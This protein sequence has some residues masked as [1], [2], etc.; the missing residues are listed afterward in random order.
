MAGDWVVV[1]PNVM[2]SE[3][4][5]NNNTGGSPA[6]GGITLGFLWTNETALC[7]TLVLGTFFLAAN[8]ILFAAI[9]RRRVACAKRDGHRQ[10]DNPSLQATRAEAVPLSYFQNEAELSIT[11]LAIAFQM[12]ADG[13][14][15]LDQK[16]Q[17]LWKLWGK[18]FLLQDSQYFIASHK[19]DL[20]NTMGVSEKAKMDTTLL[21]SKAPQTPKDNSLVKIAVEMAGKPP[22]LIEFNQKQPLATIIQDL[23]NYWNLT[24][25]ET[26]ALRF[27]TET[28]RAFVSE[29]NRLEVKNGHVLQLGFSPGK[30]T[31][32]ILDQLSPQS[33][34][35]DKMKAIQELAGYAT[36]PTFTAEFTDKLGMKTLIGYVENTESGKLS[37]QI[38]VHLLPAF[39]DLMD[40]GLTQWDVLE[41]TFI[42]R[43]ASF[44]NN[45]SSAQ[46]P[47]TLQAALSILESLAQNSSTKYGIVER[48]LTIPNLAMHL[49]NTS[50][51]IQQNTLALINAL[52]LK[53]DDSKRTAMSK[54]LNARQIRNIIVMSII[55]VPGVASGNEIAHQLHVLQTL[56]L[57]VLEEAMNCPIEPGDMEAQEKIKELRRIAFDNDGS[58]SLTPV[59]DVATRKQIIP[60]DFRKL[61]FKNDA[62]PL[63]DFAQVPPGAL[64]LDAMLYFASYH[65]EKYSRVVLENSGRGDEYDCP[66]VRAAIELIKLLCEILK[67]GEPP[68]EQG[69]LFHP[70]FFNHDHPFEELFC[71]CIVVVNK[72]WKEMRATV[73]DF[74][75]VF[76]V[77]REQIT[78]VLAGRPLTQEIFKERIAALT[79]AEITDLWQ[80]ERT[81]REKWESRS[82]P[83]MELRQ[84]I[85]PEI[86]ELIQQQR[87]GF[88]TEGT[89]FSKYTNRGRVKD[90]F[91]YVRLSPNH[92]VLH[93][94]DCDEK[95][96]PALDEL[97][98]KLPIVD[99]R[100]LVTGKDC[101]HMK[102]LKGKKTTSQYPFSLM[103]DSNDVGSLDFVAPD[104]QTF[105]YWVDGINALLGNKMT[106]KEAMADL[107]FLLSMNTKLRLLDVEG[108][109]LP[110][111]P[112]VIPREPTNYDFAVEIK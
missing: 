32:S 18:A 80:Q 49:Q 92:R 37:D 24:D 36:D 74:A 94:G 63:N 42:K 88:L 93:Y 19:S 81:S 46:D 82:R 101:P 44:I 107:E 110:E 90:K 34:H 54:T 20:S 96:V 1:N 69:T 60:R 13:N 83:I 106:S 76:S 100:T 38:T 86:V 8:L 85:E 23:C 102:D 91:W 29:K 71:I 68:T 111:E 21:R 65:P 50:P 3:T 72:T 12:L 25:A 11:I 87:L 98:D 40:H 47:R 62:T 57:N 31:Q 56:M 89:R 41:P 108:L 7:I 104:Q 51:S 15:L 4:G 48:E 97:T 78:R 73:E 58:D 39:V 28:S 43:I 105:D 45:Q 66:F 2:A 10:D 53:A 95:S 5:S 55:Q 6:V 59:K 67:I 109:D 70:M 61:G 16:V 9:Y 64:A 26:Y 27:N 30:I 22:Q 77:V 79:Y 75:K 52:F 33:S 99:I 35:E 84:Q 112:P 17:I 14:G 103:L